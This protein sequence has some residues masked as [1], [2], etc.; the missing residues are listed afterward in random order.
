MDA[1]GSA[2]VVLIVVLLWVAAALWGR[3]TRDGRDWR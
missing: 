3:D 1:F 2:I